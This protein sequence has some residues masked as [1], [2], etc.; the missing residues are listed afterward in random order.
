MS[1][2]LSYKYRAYPGTATEMRLNAALAPGRWLCNKL[3]EEGKISRKNGIAPTMRET[4][5]RIVTLKDENPSLKG[6]YS[7]MLQMVNHILWSNLAALNVLIYQ[8][9]L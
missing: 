6:V 2:L 5:A 4:R 9:Y 3:P 8:G 1:M 7:K